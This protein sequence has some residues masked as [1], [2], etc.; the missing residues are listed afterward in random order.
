MMA[1]SSVVIERWLQW[2][3]N[4][5]VEVQVL[6]AV[7]SPCRLWFGIGSGFVQHEVRCVSVGSVSAQCWF[8]SLGLHVSCV[9]VGSDLVQMGFI[10]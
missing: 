10:L 1:Y 2:M 5:P 9:S 6:L 7:G 4:S 8:S 3:C